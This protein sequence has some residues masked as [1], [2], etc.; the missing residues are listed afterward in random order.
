MTSLV[1]SEIYN[2]ISHIS[3]MF[4]KA[5]SMEY[6]AAFDLNPYREQKDHTSKMRFKASDLKLLAT[7][8]TRK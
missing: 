7:I 6:K 1:A 2:I 4:G 3:N 8:M 5:H